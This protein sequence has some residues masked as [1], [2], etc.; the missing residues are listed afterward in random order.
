MFRERLSRFLEQDSCLYPLKGE[1][2]RDRDKMS[3]D[4]I[5][6]RILDFGKRKDITI[7]VEY[8]TSAMVGI[9]GIEYYT[10]AFI[11]ETGELILMPYERSVF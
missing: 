9:T 1:T 4:E 5:I 6:E 2:I 7:K 10:I 3:K 11:D 8:I